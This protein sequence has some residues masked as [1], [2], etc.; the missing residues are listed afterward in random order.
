MPPARQAHYRFR[1]DT[2]T[3]RGGL[4][5]L[6]LPWITPGSI[7]LRSLSLPLFDIPFLLRTTITPILKRFVLSQGFKGSEMANTVE[8]ENKR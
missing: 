5:Q 4:R 1:K 6:L 2:S 7:P 3:G 8:M